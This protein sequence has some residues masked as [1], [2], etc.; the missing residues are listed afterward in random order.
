E[1][2]R[3]RRERFLRE[4]RAASMLR[5]PNVAAIYDIGESDS[6]LFIVMEYVEGELLATQLEAGPLDVYQA[7]DIAT[8]VGEELDEAHGLGI[9]HR[10]IK[11]SNLMVTP[12]GLVKVLDFGLAKMGRAARSVDGDGTARRGL[13]TTPGVILGTLAYMSPEQA[14]G[15][16]V[17]HRSDLF[18]LGVLLYEM[19]TGHQPFAGQ[20]TGDLL[21]AILSREPEPLALATYSTE[22]QWVIAKALRKDK[23]LRYQTA[24]DFSVDLKNLSQGM[25]T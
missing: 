7:I 2:D 19:L 11:S 1:Y 9:I 23:T 15:L 13:E 5:S 8:Q 12:R 17:D 14:R 16:D 20:T 4:A 25:S 22:M 24:R 3:E 10:D 6:T 21:V 18:S